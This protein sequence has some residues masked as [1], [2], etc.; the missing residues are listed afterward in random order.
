ML[1]VQDAMVQEEVGGCTYVVVVFLVFT[2]LVDVGSVGGAFGCGGR[3][4][5]HGSVGS[6]GMKSPM[7]RRTARRRGGAG[8]GRTGRRQVGSPRIQPC[9]FLFQGIEDNCPGCLLGSTDNRIPM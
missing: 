3:G 5:C 6:S 7:G 4:G 1:V 2:T 8:R 9:P